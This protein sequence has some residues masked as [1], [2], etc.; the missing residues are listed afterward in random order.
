MQLVQTHNK[1]PVMDLRSPKSPGWKNKFETLTRRRLRDDQDD[2][3]A[4]LDIMTENLQ[5]I[6]VQYKQ[7]VLRKS[8]AL[9]TWLG[10]DNDQIVV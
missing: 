3:M 9:K 6:Q 1:T 7:V 4:E 10:P 2:I 5:Q 8:Q